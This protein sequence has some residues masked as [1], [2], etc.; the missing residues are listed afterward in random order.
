MQLLA[1]LHEGLRHSE[2]FNMLKLIVRG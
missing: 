1:M 2:F